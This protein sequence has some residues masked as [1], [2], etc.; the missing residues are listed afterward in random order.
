MA[1]GGSDEED[2][3]NFRGLVVFCQQGCA[4]EAAFRHVRLV[5]QVE[6]VSGRCGDAPFKPCAQH[7]RLRSVHH[8]LAPFGTRRRAEILSGAAILG[9]GVGVGRQRLPQRPLRWRA[10]LGCFPCGDDIEA[11]CCRLLHPQD[12][13]RRQEPRARGEAFSGHLAQ[14]LRSVR[15]QL[16]RRVWSVDVPRGGRG[17]HGAALASLGQIDRSIS[18]ALV[19]GGGV[20]PDKR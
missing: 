18:P 19:P 6:Q 2:S 17:E 8:Q 14:P 15:C 13:K 10:C 3:W 4:G 12:A 1:N 20:C 7:G 9:A 5:R 11:S 16:G